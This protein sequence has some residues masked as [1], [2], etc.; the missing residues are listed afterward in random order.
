MSGELRPVAVDLLR[1]HSTEVAPRL[2]NLVLAADGASGRIV[3]VEAYAGVDDPASHARMGETR[4]NAT[5]FRRAGLGYVYFTY[6]MHWCVNVVTGE[7]GSGQAVLLRALEPLTGIELM[8]TR[9]RAARRDVDLTNGPAKLCEA[10]GVRG[11]LDGVDLLDP[12]SPLRLLSDGTPPPA[13]PGRS[14]RVGITAAAERPWR[15]FVPH[16][17]YVSRHPGPRP[18]RPR[19]RSAVQ[20]AAD[21]P[22]PAQQNGGGGG[23]AG[24]GGDGAGAHG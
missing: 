3:E 2:L 23:A 21:R 9:R 13:E 7:D 18:S 1:G 10:L 11:E 6:G 14:T 15:W 22:D 20:V 16:S 17:P 12:S 24:G 8:R 4:R 19:S 5:M